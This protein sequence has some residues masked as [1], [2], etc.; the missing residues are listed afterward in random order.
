[1][2]NIGSV[3]MLAFFGTLISM[4]VTFFCVYGLSVSGL[5]ILNTKDIL[6]LSALIGIASLFYQIDGFSGDFIS[7]Q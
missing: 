2:Y 1:M 3:V 5:T 7:V 4:A 6:V